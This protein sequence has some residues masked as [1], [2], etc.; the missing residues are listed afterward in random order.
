MDLKLTETNGATVAEPVSNDAVIATV[1]EA[2]D[3]IATAGWQGATHVL[4][5]EAHLA[6]AFFDLRS[7]LAGEI[8]QKATNYGMGVL[9]VG[10]FAAHPSESLQAFIRES[11][12]GRQV[13]FVADREAALRKVAG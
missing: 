4:L 8:L 1:R 13:A 12:R 9:I 11:N 10:D 2:L 3:L 5:H 7:G 6:P